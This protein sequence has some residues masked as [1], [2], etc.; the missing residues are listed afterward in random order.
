V[1]ATLREHL[2]HGDLDAFR[3]A[4]ASLHT[5]EPSAALAALDE[6]AARYDLPCLR[7]LLA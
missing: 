5:A 6:A 4:V 3:A 1:L 7:A 2:A